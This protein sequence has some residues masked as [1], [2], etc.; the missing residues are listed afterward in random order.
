MLIGLLANY[1]T[2]YQL[3]STNCKIL[4]TDY[5]TSRLAIII[6]IFSFILFSAIDSINTQKGLRH[7]QR[8]NELYQ[9]E[10]YMDASREFELA[11]KYITKN[12]LLMQMQAKCFAMLE[13]WN[14]AIS[15][16]HQV[17]DYRNGQIV[18]IILGDAYKAIGNYEKSEEAYKQAC[19]IIPHR[20]LPNFLLV[21]MYNESGHDIKALRLAKEL[22]NKRPKVVTIAIIEMRDELQN[23]INQRK[24]EKRTGSE[25]VSKH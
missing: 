10:L 8:A 2:E 1:L 15:I 24:K 12:G 9:F 22:L 16:A 4:S 14:E 21:K 5:L 7:L 23:I 6:L 19:I 13:K 25:T 17:Q 3:Q 20:F 18:N 11:K